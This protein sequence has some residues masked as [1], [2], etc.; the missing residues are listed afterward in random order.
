MKNQLI[1]RAQ[2][3]GRKSKLNIWEIKYWN[4]EYKDETD[5]YN[6]LKKL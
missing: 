6:S 2:R 3:F 4:E 1:G 5:M